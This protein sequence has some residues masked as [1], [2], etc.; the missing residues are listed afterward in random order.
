[1]S[2]S[3]KLVHES[4]G[5]CLL[6]GIREVGPYVSDV[7]QRARRKLLINLRNGKRVSVRRLLPH[8][9]PGGWLFPR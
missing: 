3:L 8:D 7:D 4:L 5:T 1:M 6:G 9:L 2:Q